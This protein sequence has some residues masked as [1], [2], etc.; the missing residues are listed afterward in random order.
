MI[1]VALIELTPIPPPAER[2]RRLLLGNFTVV[3][4][5][6]TVRRCALFEEGTRRWAVPPRCHHEDA[7]VHFSPALNRYLTRIVGKEIASRTKTP[8]GISEGYAL[9]EEAAPGASPSLSAFP[10][11]PGVDD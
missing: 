3:I 6:V 5:G 4:G 8:D 2:G 9:A 7:E 1:D 10:L 11:R